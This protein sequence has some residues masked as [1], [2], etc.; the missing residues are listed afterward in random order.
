MKQAEKKFNLIR[1]FGQ[2]GRLWPY[3]R[4]D[5]KLIY[6]AMMMVPLVSVF[7]AWMPH[8][9]QHTIDEGIAHGNAAA[10]SMG[11]LW[12]LVATIGAYAAR[13][14]QSVTSALAVHRMTRELRDSMVKHILK[15]D[16]SYHDRTL[17]GTLVTRATSDFDNLNESLNQG[18][19]TSIV[20][21]AVL[22]GCFVGL[23]MLDWRLSLI[24]MIIL[25]MVAMI[26]NKFSSG[27][28]QSLLDS[29]VRI[30]ALNAFTQ[31]CL[32]GASTVKLLRAQKSAQQR[33]DRLNLEFRDAQMKSVV[34]DALMFS[35]I[36]GIAAVTIGLIL[37]YAC[38]ELGF[39][40]MIS[41]GLLVAF[42]TYIQQLFEPIKQLGNKIAMLQGAFTSIDRIFTVLD[43]K[44]FISGDQP[45]KL[46]KGEVVFDHVGFSYR[47]ATPSSSSRTGV[48]GER[49]N[50]ISQSKT[51]L[52]DLSFAVK[53]GQS[54]AI[55]G[56]TGS[57]KSTIIKLLTKLYDGYQGSIRIDGKDIRNML[58]EDLRQHVAIVPQDIVLFDGDVNFNIGLGNRSITDKMIQ[59]AATAVGADSFIQAL[60]DGYKTLLREQGS[61]LSHGQRQLIAFARAL[62]KNPAMVVLDEATSS[63]DPQS[64]RVIQDAIERILANRTVIVIAHRLSTI[65]KCDQIMVMDHGKVVEIGNHDQLLANRGAYFELHSAL[66]SH[67][68]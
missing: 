54:L 7:Q 50:E 52:H 65:R 23:T 16:C 8:I 44:E 9:I 48:D 40:E 51:V 67:G 13:A 5:R 61:N 66:Y 37:W 20:D 12:F 28:K 42:V 34:L 2:L 36:D 43:Q 68:K 19:L 56:H 18:V 46:P 49:L 57:G 22:V 39:S 1:D 27:M 21:I 30:S 64:E 10:V 59:D 15:L 24:T 53:S 32:Y 29:R 62:A 60:P 25:P 55:V 3:L 58:D 63:V 33:F 11:A 17:S 31:E 14:G 45:V 26:V 35:V 4:K 38:S 41:A 47:I 6:I